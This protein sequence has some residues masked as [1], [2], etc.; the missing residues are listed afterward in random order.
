ME[1][2]KIVY[3]GTT[4]TGMPITIGYPLIDDV[5]QMTEYINTLSLEETYILRQGRQ[6]TLES[7]AK[8]VK[9]VLEK[10]GNKQEV[11]LEV[12]TP[13]KLIGSSGIILRTD[14]AE[15]EGVFGISLAKEYRGQ[16]I[17][18]LL[19]HFVLEEAEKELPALKIVTLGVF[20]DNPIAKHMYESFGFKEFGRLPKG[21]LHKGNYVDHIYMYKDVNG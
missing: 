5:A 21:I 19:M 3:Q 2:R 18:K 7:E 10:I 17:G 15:H 1:K 6:E 20:G 11:Y 14:S 4:Q 8:Y 9:E 13:N 16:G 12:F